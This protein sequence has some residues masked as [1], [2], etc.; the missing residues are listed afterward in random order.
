MLVSSGATKAPGERRTDMSWIRRLWKQEE[1]QGMTEYIVIVALVAIA[2]I[3]VV[4]V[5]GDNVRKIFGTSVDALAG[6]GSGSTGAKTQ[7][8]TAATRGLTDFA[9]SASKQ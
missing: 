9:E 5:Y 2:A 1:G 6:K 7:G 8:K 3:G 4:S